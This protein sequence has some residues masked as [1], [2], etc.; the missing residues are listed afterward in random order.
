MHYLSL[1]ECSSSPVATYAYKGTPVTIRQVAEDL[2]VQYVLEG[3]IVK[4]GDRLRVTAQLI[5]AMGGHH[6]WAEVYD[7]EMRELF[8]LQDE[9]TKKIVVSI[10]VELGGGEDVRV[11]AKSTD[12]LEAWKRSTKGG[13]LISYLNIE[14]NAKAREYFEAALDLDPEYVAAMSLLAVTHLI[15]YILGWSDSPLTS[16]NRASKLAQKAVELDEQNPGAHMT[17]GLVLLHR[18]QHE[19]AITEGILGIKLNPNYCLGHAQLGQIMFFPDGLR[20]QLV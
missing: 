3:S 12:N 5:D 6:L 15:D 2:G 17:L 11:R 10:G 16:M 7:R 1:Q 9:I 19:K 13:P 8:E 20:R 4:S 18:R 14:D